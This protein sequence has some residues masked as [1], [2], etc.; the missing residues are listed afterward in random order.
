MEVEEGTDTLCSLVS[1]RNNDWKQNKETANTTDEQVDTDKRAY[2][3]NICV[4]DS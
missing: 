3:C 2:I 1:V 4:N